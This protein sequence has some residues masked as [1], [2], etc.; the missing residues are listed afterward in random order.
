MTTEMS[1]QRTEK[2]SPDGQSA[3]TQER[4]S[5]IDARKKDARIAGVLFV[6]ATVASSLGFVILGPILQAPDL[7][8]AVSANST[9]L[10]IGALLLLLNCAV[11]VAI[12]V[13][14]FPILNGR[15]EVSAVA[16][17]S[18]RIIE[19]AILI[20]GAISLLS[21]FTLSQGSAP[22]GAPNASDFQSVGALLLAVYDWTL[23]LGIMIVFGL[24]A[25]ILNGALYR[26]QLV[27]R[28]LSGWGLIGALVLLAVG[29]LAVFGF[30]SS[31]MWSL[32]IALQEM[33]L[34]VWLIV[35]GFEP[36][37]FAAE[38]EE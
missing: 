4:V 5:T 11:V 12:P 22:T 28:W 10:M 27:P 7:L 20:A 1:L 23:L 38:S 6:I 19:S 24:T 29:L 32:P 14:L 8:V 26:S 37:A 33:V 15:N 13:M 36:T 34:A 17:L 21:L 31:E 30:D 18:S 25:L 35:K 16:Y 2:P 3:T 9:Q